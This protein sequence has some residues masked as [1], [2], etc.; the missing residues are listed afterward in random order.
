MPAKA[1]GRDE[2]TGSV[3][4][5]WTLALCKVR[6]DKSLGRSMKASS[7]TA[8]ALLSLGLATGTAAQTVKVPAKPA[9]AP[10][11]MAAMPKG[12]AGRGATAF[13]VCKSCHVV[14]A[15][16]NRIGPTLYGIVGRKSGSVPGYA[17]SAANKAKGVVWTQPVLFTYLEN[18]RKFIPGTKMA[19]AGLKDPQKRA[20][21]IAFLATKK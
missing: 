11:A 1:G 10:A 8:A 12:D 9:A 13:V 15:G 21:V 7:I 5:A 16:K 3:A 18:P 4:I 14:E 2:T 6:V 20:D 19:Y 17:Y